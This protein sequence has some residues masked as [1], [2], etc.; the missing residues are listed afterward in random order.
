MFFKDVFPDYTVK[1]L[2]RGNLFSRCRSLKF[3]QIGDIYNR[4]LTP[5]EGNLAQINCDTSSHLLPVTKGESLRLLDDGGDYL[6]VKNRQGIVGW[7]PREV[8]CSKS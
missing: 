8:M 2:S 7:V 3:G 1:I 4:H 6:F 5:L